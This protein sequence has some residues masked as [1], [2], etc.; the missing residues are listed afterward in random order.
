ML[1]FAMKGDYHT[2][3]DFHHH[4]GLNLFAMR[5]RYFK[6]EKWLHVE[7]GDGA[8]RVNKIEGLLMNTER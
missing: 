6:E 3:T 5:L 4:S 7:E 2:S 1:I 8:E